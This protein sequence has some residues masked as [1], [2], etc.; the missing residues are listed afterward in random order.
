MLQPVIQY[1]SGNVFGQRA[2]LQSQRIRLIL[3]IP[4]RLKS[5]LC[6]TKIRLMLIKGGR[7]SLLYLAK[8]WTDDGDICPGKVCKLFSY[9]V[10]H[11][12]WLGITHNNQKTIFRT[13]PSV[14]IL[15][16]Q[17]GISHLK[18]GLC[19]NRITPGNSCARKGKLHSLLKHPA[20]CGI[21]GPF[22]RKNDSPLPVYLLFK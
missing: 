9:K 11:K 22:F 8:I 1:S 10:F 4:D 17:A 16:Q 2:N 20:A 6:I 14:V 15:P 18:C 5:H 12:S 3:F 13:V 19:S 21:T 7:T